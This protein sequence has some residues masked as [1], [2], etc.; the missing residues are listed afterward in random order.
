MPEITAEKL[1]SDLTNLAKDS[2][3]L[4]VGFAVLA[5]Q[6]AQVQRQNLQTRLDSQLGAGKTQLDKVSGT[7]ETQL[8]GLDQR[9]TALETRIDTIL[10]KLEATLPEQAR[11]AMKQARD[12][13]RT[14]RE[15]VRGLVR[16]KVAE[17]SDTS[18][19]AAEGAD[20]EG[21]VAAA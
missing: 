17:G 18:D 5:V 16:P 7:M 11:D 21:D 15:Q 4:T 20:A 8:A 9:L 1:A 19:V 13:A 2:V 12:A 6:K 14:A 3:Y 10:D